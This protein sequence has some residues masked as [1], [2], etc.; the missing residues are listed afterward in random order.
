[1]QIVVTQKGNI[2]LSFLNKT[3]FRNRWFKGISSFL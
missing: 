3:L 2:E 1:L